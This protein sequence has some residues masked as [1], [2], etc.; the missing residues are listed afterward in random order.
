MTEEGVG[1]MG[2]RIER[3]GRLRVRP[4]DL[5]SRGWY[6]RF[7]MAI[8]FVLLVFVVGVFVLA[9][10]RLRDQGESY[11]D[12]AFIFGS[13]FVLAIILVFSVRR[14][15]RRTYDQNDE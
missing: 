8:N 11:G 7:W 12:I 4:P 5:A 2:R 13:I 3:L 9:P 15:V 6:W 14:Y 10:F 1:Q